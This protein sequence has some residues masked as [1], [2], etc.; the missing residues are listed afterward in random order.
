MIF[1]VGFCSVTKY[2]KKKKKKGIESSNVRHRAFM[3]IFFCHK[4]NCFANDFKAKFIDS[5]MLLL[6]W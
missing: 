4:N 1:S 3:H 2:Q 6:P 5:L